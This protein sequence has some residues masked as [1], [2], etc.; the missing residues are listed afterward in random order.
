MALCYLYFFN[1]KKE[2]PNHTVLRKHTVQMTSSY[3]VGFNYVPWSC[4]IGMSLSWHI[5]C[6]WKTEYSQALRLFVENLTICWH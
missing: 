5:Y 2:K 3:F 6:Q 1:L 4:I